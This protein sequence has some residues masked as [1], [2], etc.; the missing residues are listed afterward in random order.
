MGPF[1]RWVFNCF[2]RFLTVWLQSIPQNRLSILERISKSYLLFL[3]NYF[4]Q[5]NIIFGS[6]ILNIFR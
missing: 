1:W 5:S 6:I 3:I 2:F 4:Q